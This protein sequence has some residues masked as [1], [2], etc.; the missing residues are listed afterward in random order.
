VQCVLSINLFNEKIFI[1]LW[2]WFVVV[3]LFNLFDLA[4][5]IYTLII[6][7]HERYTYIK[8][9]LTVLNS[10]SQMPP[11]YLS[12]PNERLMFRKF[13][14]NYLREDG[15]LALRLLSRNAHDLIVSEVIL[16]LF[17]MYKSQCRQR[18]RM[19]QRM[20]ARTNNL[21]APPPP[22]PPPP[23]SSTLHSNTDVGFRVNPNTSKMPISSFS[24]ITETASNNNSKLNK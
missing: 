20:N 5:W 10:S 2:F 14:N 9:R 17:N 19:E 16:N 13:V 12:N 7:S 3:S 22:P 11:D 4:S 18:E 1:F 21:Q 23:P 6:N 8:R 24:T 15:V